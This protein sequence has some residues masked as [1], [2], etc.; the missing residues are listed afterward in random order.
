MSTPVP[1]VIAIDGPSGSGKSTTSKL[2][3]TDLNC[4]YLDTG[5]IYRAL[6]WWC[7][8]QQIPAADADRVAAAAKELPIEITAEPDC[9]AVLLDGRNVTAELHRPQISAIVSG[10]ANVP[11]ARQILTDLMREIIRDAGR[12]VVEGRDITTVVA[13]DADLRVLLQA[14]AAARVAR[15]EAQLNGEA[16][17]ATVTRQV[18]GRDRADAL[19]SQFETPAAGVVLIDSTFLAPAEVVA[20][21]ESL[22]PEDLRG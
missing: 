22:V 17:H 3:A 19:S 13:P 2:V 20:R 9:F 4:A 16:D 6:A 10:Y 7:D 11:A 12:I 14:D 5:S 8:H 15:R 1:L 21:V 18:V